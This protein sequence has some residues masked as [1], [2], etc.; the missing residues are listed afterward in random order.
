MLP[1]MYIRIYE[2]NRI[3]LRISFYLLG[4]LVLTSMVESESINCTG[5][6]DGLRNVVTLTADNFD[7][8]LAAN[9][10]FVLFHGSGYE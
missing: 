7:S 10:H 3:T 8:K 1:T 2:G 5:A 9:Y 4:I 6:L